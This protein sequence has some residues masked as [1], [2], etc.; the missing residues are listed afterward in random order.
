MLSLLS[1]QPYTP[2]SSA[3][4]SWPRDS[5]GCLRSYLGGFV[6]HARS[7]S[8][9]G[10]PRPLPQQVGAHDGVQRGGAPHAGLPGPARLLPSS[11]TGNAG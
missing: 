11:S 2:F 3:A 6:I 10:I 4:L 1:P 7:S 8:S 9:F 5:P